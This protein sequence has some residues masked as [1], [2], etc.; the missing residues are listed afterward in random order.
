[1]Q[2]VVK[3]ADIS[4]P[5]RYLNCRY[6][7]FLITERPNAVMK[8]WSELVVSEFFSQGDEERSLGLPIS[9]FMDRTHSNC[10][11]GQQVTS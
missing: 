11:K 6:I 4:N 5:A 8:K 3:I 9:T 10:I 7:F 2:I 1:M